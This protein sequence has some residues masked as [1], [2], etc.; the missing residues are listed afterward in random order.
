MVGK[1]RLSKSELENT[2]VGELMS[3]K[4]T[5]IT[6]STSVS[7]C[8]RVMLDNGLRHLPVMLWKDIGVDGHL[9]LIRDLWELSLLKL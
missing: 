4:P 3:S 5:P 8:I 1:D 6:P 2:R 7:T 9:D